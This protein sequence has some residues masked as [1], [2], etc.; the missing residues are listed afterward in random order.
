MLFGLFPGYTSTA[1]TLYEAIL[2]QKKKPVKWICEIFFIDTENPEV[3]LW[4]RGPR[5]THKTSWYISIAYVV[6]ILVGAHYFS[7]VG[8]TREVD[9]LNI[10]VEETSF[11]VFLL[12]TWLLPVYFMKRYLKK[13]KPEKELDR[14][15]YYD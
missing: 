15:T 8:V 4:A 14:Y 10:I 7:W 11:P 9:A 5:R 6:M 12:L 3:A 2:V 1:G 13:L